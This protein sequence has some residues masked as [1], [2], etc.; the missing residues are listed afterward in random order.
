MADTWIAV[1][2][3]QEDDVL[4]FHGRSFVSAA[5]RLFDGTEVNHAADFLAARGK[6]AEAHWNGV[7]LR[8]PAT[9]F[10][11]SEYVLVYRHKTAPPGKAPVTAR[12]EHYLSLGVRYAYESLVLLAFLS[13]TR[14]VPVTSSFDRFLRTVVEAA[15]GALSRW[16]SSTGTRTAMICSEFV[17]RVYDEALPLPNHPYSVEVGPPGVTAASIPPPRSAARARRHSD[18]ASVLGLLLSSSK[19]RLSVPPKPG[20]A[21]SRRRYPSRNQVEAMAKEY[22]TGLAS[23]YG[24][25]AL[26][27]A[28][29]V[30]Q[31]DQFIMDFAHAWQAVAGKQARDA[32]SARL[33]VPDPLEFLDRTAPSL[34][35]PGDL[36]RSGSL[37]RAGRVIISGPQ[38]KR[39]A[40]GLGLRTASAVNPRR[41][42]NAHST[43][44]C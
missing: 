44:E 23:G 28:M 4:L 3:L 33:A 40:S 31:D 10:A 22:I 27:T 32:K 9:S 37:Y 21:Q 1:P 19:S 13:L 12:A 7:V 16:L 36:Y 17:Y 6:V 8:S 20:I 25:G 14:R 24:G 41:A 29:A 42:K 15:T 11:D 5:I 30:P 34:V 39:Q 38:K 35:T 26:A 2:E 18:P 43:K